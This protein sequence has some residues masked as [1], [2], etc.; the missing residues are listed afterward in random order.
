MSIN[1]LN[2]QIGGGDPPV[3]ELSITEQIVDEASNQLVSLFEGNVVEYIEEQQETVETVELVEEI[4]VPEPLEIRE[5]FIDKK[6]RHKSWCRAE[7]RT[8]DHVPV[9][10][11]LD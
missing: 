8:S 10:I 11:L 6:T 4:S 3:E 5:D 2:L 7:P 1:K 9:R